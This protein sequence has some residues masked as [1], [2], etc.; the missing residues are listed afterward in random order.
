MEASSRLG[1]LQASILRK[2]RLKKSYKTTGAPDVAFGLNPESGTMMTKLSWVVGVASILLFEMAY[3]IVHIN[4]AVHIFMARSSSGKPSKNLTSQDPSLIYADVDM[5]AVFDQIDLSLETLD[6]RINLGYIPRTKQKNPEN[7]V[8]KLCGDAFDLYYAD[9]KR[10][11]SSASDRFRQKARPIV[12]GTD[13]CEAMRK[14]HGPNLRIAIAGMFNTGTNAFVRNLQAN[15]GIPGHENDDMTNSSNA[16][17]L[18]SYEINQNGI[19]YEVPWWKHHPNIV[20]TSWARYRDPVQHSHVLPVV[21]VRDPLNWMLSTCKSQYDLSWRDD[22]ISKKQRRLS[23]FLP[24]DVSKQVTEKK[25]RYNCP[26]MGYLDGATNQ[27]TTTPIRFDMHQVLQ[28]N[29]TTTYMQVMQRNGKPLT[30]IHQRPKTVRHYESF[31]HLWNDFYRQYYDADFPRLI[32]RFEDCMYL[33]PQVLKEIQH[34]V[35]GYSKTNTTEQKLDNGKDHGGRSNLWSALRKNSDPE[36]RLQ[37]ISSHSEFDYA[38]NVLDSTMM[39]AF[40]Y[41]MP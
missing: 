23:M 37:K 10:N 27:T 12:L 26:K 29:S 19:N 16:T 13:Q 30:K 36:G 40:N 25:V 14:A 33:F 20:N 21:M 2:L 32:V 28:G 35:N 41:Q 15:I 7:F 39:E 17:K 18:L 11:V 38:R 1:C 8:E 34:C 24:R 6:G 22:S 4:N 3:K 31:L 9:R 5:C